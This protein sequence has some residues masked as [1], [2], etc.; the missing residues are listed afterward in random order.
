M[1]QYQIL[2]TNIARTVCQTIRRITNE[3]LGV[4]GLKDKYQVLIPTTEI[5]KTSLC[6]HLHPI[7]TLGIPEAL[8]KNRKN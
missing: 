6:I 5:G 7:K 8:L 2:H 4:K 1:I 3:V